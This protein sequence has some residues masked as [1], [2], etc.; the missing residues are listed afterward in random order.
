MRGCDRCALCATCTCPP[1]APRPARTPAPVL[2]CARD[3]SGPVPR[4]RRRTT[5][6]RAFGRRARVRSSG[7]AAANHRRGHRVAARASCR[8]SPR[9]RRIRQ[10]GRAPRDH[11]GRDGRRTPG[12]GRGA[13]VEPCD[14]FLP[15]RPSPLAHRRRAA[16]DA[17]RDGPDARDRQPAEDASSSGRRVR[18]GACRVPGQGISVARPGGD[19]RR[20]APPAARSDWRGQDGTWQGDVVAPLI[21]DLGA[22]LA[23]RPER[24][25]PSAWCSTRRWARPVRRWTAGTCTSAISTGAS[26]RPRRRSRSAA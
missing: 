5:S 22:A 6:I 16:R 13:L 14:G 11:A 20:R 25:R 24:P 26:C 1:P 18:Y 19:L 12:P 17:A 9:G 10:C 23:M 4:V 8:G 3:S 15:A 2:R 21:R 7:Q